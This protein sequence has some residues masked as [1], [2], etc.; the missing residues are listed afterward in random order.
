MKKETPLHPPT[1]RAQGVAAIPAE[2]LPAFRYGIALLSVVAATALRF[3]FAPILGPYQFPFITYFPV[4]AFSAWIGGFGPGALCVLLSTLCSALLFLPPN[5]ASLLHN[6]ANIWSLVIFV[7]TGLGISALGESQRK[8][9]G[10][11]EANAREAAQQQRATKQE[12]E[13]LAITLRSIGDAVITTDANGRIRAMNGVAEMLT[14]WTEKEAAGKPCQEIFLIHNED[15]GEEVESPVARVLREG[16]IVGL[17][18]H[19][20]LTARDGTKRFI[21][22]SGAPIRDEKGE[23]LGVVLVF[24]D[25]SARRRSEKAQIFLVESSETLASSLDYAQT[26]QKVARLAVPHIAD[27]CTVDILNEAGSLELLA[28]AHIDPAKVQWAYALREKY[29]P[30]PDHERGLLHVV[31]TGEME[32]YPE[33]TEDFLI[34]TSRD[35]AHL[36]LLRQVG[37]ASAM[38]VPMIAR[39]RTLGAISFITTTESKHYFTEEDQE[40][41][42][43]LAAR[44]ALAVDNARLYQ[45]A[46]AE[47][48]ERV[49]TEEELRRS[50]NQL[51]VIL[52]GIGDGITAQEPGGKIVFANTAAARAS[53]FESVEEFLAM[54]PLEVVARFEMLDE[55]G[56]PF[57]PSQLPGRLALQGEVPAPCTLRVRSRQTGQERWVMIKAHPVRDETGKVV[58]AINFFEEVTELREAENILRQRQAEI[59]ALNARLRR[60]MSETHH[61]VKNNLQVIAA[62]VQMQTMER[63]PTVPVEELQRLNQ[64]IQALAAIH[65]LLTQ[66]ARADGAVDNFSVRQVMEKLLPVMQAMAQNTIQTQIEDVSLPVRHGTSLAVIIN[67]LVSNALKHGRGD[68]EISFTLAG[69]QANLEVCDDG[70][71]FPPDFDPV[72]AAHTGLELIESLSRWDLQGT[73]RYENRIE[74]G[75]RV[76]VEFPLPETLLVGDNLETATPPL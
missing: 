30:T 42:E 49:R 65:D 2:Y 22:D 29:P 39:G 62:L 10:R 28:V 13:L 74:G 68:V 66:Q 44:A 20:I 9:Q 15:T 72:T 7:C 37:F 58:M 57:P 76:I 25:I 33:I 63:G 16:A 36:A 73:T 11:A 26:L 48:V 53:G 38:I 54:P 51:Q 4:V 69:K 17:A 31:Q 23:M 47:I 60:S 59:E 18:N 5:S 19:T 6:S 27:W 70:T 61:R 8:A 12:Q 41:A 67:E 21:D 40:L 50:R 75:A 56:E 35:E 52:E 3:L 46:Q 24:R 71:G 32:V 1:V 45:A 64:H 14:G 43:G 34:A 55:E